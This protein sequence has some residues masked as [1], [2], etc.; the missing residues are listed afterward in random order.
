[1]YK[2]LLKIGIT[3]PRYSG[4]ARPV[5]YTKAGSHGGHS[6]AVAPKIL[7]FPGTFGLNI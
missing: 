7:L 5:G 4:E 3:F 6:E 2:L 1:M